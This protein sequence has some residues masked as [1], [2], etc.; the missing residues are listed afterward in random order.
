MVR[1]IIVVFYSYRIFSTNQWRR[2]PRGTNNLKRIWNISNMIKICITWCSA[3]IIQSVTLATELPFQNKHKPVVHVPIFP[4]FVSTV[5]P[6]ATTVPTP[7][8]GP[9]SVKS[10]NGQSVWLLIRKFYILVLFNIQ[11]KVKYI[12]VCE[13]TMKSNFI[14]QMS[15]LHGQMVYVYAPAVISLDRDK[16][17]LF[18]DDDSPVVSTTAYKFIYL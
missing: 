18:V 10:L 14:L 2:T 3:N 8:I 1:R 9:C 12:I 7:E 4:K 5:V 15:S 11:C 16:Y 13:L 6:A 17:V